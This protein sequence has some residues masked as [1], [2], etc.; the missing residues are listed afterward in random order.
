VIIGGEPQ[1]ENYGDFQ[2]EMNLFNKTFYE[3]MMEGMQRDDHL[4]FQFQPFP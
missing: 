2:D 4:L 3:V 1:K